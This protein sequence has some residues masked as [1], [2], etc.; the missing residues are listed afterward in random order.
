MKEQDLL[1]L[2]PGELTDLGICPTCFNKKHESHYDWKKCLRKRRDLKKH[3][4]NTNWYLL[5]VAVK[6]ILI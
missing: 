4:L 3:N 1:K 5:Y 6:S 2:T